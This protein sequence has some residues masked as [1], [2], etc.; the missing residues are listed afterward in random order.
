[1]CWFPL[2]I[3]GLLTL[4]PHFPLGRG[5]HTLLSALVMFAQ[6]RQDWRWQSFHPSFP[7]L[8]FLRFLRGQG[9]LRTSQ[10]S[11]TASSV[12][13]SPDRADQPGEFSG[14]YHAGEK[15]QSQAAA[16]AFAS[17]PLSCF[18]LQTTESSHRFL[19]FLLPGFCLSLL[20]LAGASASTLDEP[21]PQVGC[22][23]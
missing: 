18:Q 5:L 4:G 23:P 8:S 1:M 6:P 2:R 16:R 14:N 10:G 11:G 17:S 9:Q 15:L 20:G 19:P 13:S 21:E 12:P 3:P 22:A 7:C